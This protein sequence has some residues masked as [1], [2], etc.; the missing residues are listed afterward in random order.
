MSDGVRRGADLAV[1]DGDAKYRFDTGSLRVVVI[2]GRCRRGHR[3]AAG[4]RV[5]D[6][7]SVLVVRCST[8]AAAGEGNPSW[9]LRS[10][11]PIANVAEL[12]DA[13]YPDL[14]R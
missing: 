6:S 1:L 3:L 10:V 13:A 9:R 11:P 5:R 12:D 14:D 7:G 2:P 8:C 4:Y